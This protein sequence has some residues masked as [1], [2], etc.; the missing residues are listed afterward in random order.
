MFAHYGI[1]DRADKAEALARTEKHE[2]VLRETQNERAE[3][4]QNQGKMHPKQGK[5]RTT[6]NWL[7]DVQ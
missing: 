3:F 1:V 2:Q 4:G 7:T 6:F 5:T